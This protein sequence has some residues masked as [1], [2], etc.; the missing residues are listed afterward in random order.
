MIILKEIKKRTWYTVSALL[1]FC[2]VSLLRNPMS[3]FVLVVKK[4]SKQVTS[5]PYLV[6]QG[7]ATW[8]EVS[9]PPFMGWLFCL[10]LVW[11]HLKPQHMDWVAVVEFRFNTPSRLPV[12]EENGYVCRLEKTSV[13]ILNQQTFTQCLPCVSLTDKSKKQTVRGVCSWV[14]NRHSLADSHSSAR[15]GMGAGEAPRRSEEHGLGQTPERS[16]LEG[17]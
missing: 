1:P 17:D 9:G 2:M 12:Q 14:G 5:F 15:A 16:I 6:Y 13:M 8:A 10:F 3:S 11:M 4:T 7:L